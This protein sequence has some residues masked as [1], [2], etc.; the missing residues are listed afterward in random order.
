MFLRLSSAIVFRSVARGV[1]LLERQTMRSFGSL[2]C[3]IALVFLAACAS[4]SKAVL[5][6][7]LNDEPPF[8]LSFASSDPVLSEFSE[9]ARYVRI[10][11]E[12][13]LSPSSVLTLQWAPEGP[14]T[15]RYQ[16]VD[17]HD[18]YKATR[19]YVDSKGYIHTWLSRQVSVYDVQR[20]S[21]DRTIAK[22]LETIWT[23]L[24]ELTFYKEPGYD[25]ITYTVEAYRNSGVQR[26]MQLWSP[27]CPETGEYLVGLF[28]ALAH[29]P[30]SY[31]ASPSEVNSLSHLSH[32]VASRNG[33]QPESLMLARIAEATVS[34][35]ASQEAIR[36]YKYQLCSPPHRLPD[37][38][39]SPSP[40]CCG[41]RAYLPSTKELL[42][43]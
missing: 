25:G 22:A 5:H 8:Q 1:G 19:Q 17:G 33:Q 2:I 16:F 37:G 20:T 11:I 35:S 34:V 32:E 28:N 38:T 39:M 6:A 12:P 40:K 24:N 30:L 41:G 29:Y 26:R 42:E 7:P 36:S 15:I 23:Q 27:E 4:K 13:A 14:A 10:I 21:S 31:Q 18:Y 3:L 43:K 9:S